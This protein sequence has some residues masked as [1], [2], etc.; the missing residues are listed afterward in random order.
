MQIFL[1]HNRKIYAE[2]DDNGP[3]EIRPEFTF[4]T[5]SPQEI[6]QKLDQIYYYQLL[7]NLY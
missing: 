4:K 1:K 7:W 6:K 3:D 5:L 2:F